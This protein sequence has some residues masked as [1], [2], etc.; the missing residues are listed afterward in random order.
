MLVLA[1]LDFIAIA[2]A[3][4]WLPTAETG[5]QY[6]VSRCGICG[7]QTGNARSFSMSVLFNQCLMHKLYRDINRKITINK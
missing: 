5:V 4:R 1:K 7:R 3:V 2:Q 6:Q